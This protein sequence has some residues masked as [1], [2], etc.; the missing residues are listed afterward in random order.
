M[1]KIP[2]ESDELADKK[3]TKEFSEDS[4]WDKLQNFALKAG[5]KLVYHVLVLYYTLQKKETPTWAKTII[6]GALGYFILP[7][8]FIPD[9]FIGIG[10]T[11]D[12]GTIVMALGTVIQYVDDTVRVK[13]KETMKKWFNMDDFDAAEAELEVK[14]LSDGKNT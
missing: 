11:D 9:F 2:V 12:L 3:F 13:A 10:F 6:I 8:D 1:K 4:F 7:F 5:E 14:K